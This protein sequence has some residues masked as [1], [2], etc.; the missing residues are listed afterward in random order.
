MKG[1]KNQTKT[2]KQQQQQNP[3]KTQPLNLSIITDEF[4]KGEEIVCR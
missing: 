4:R 1:G 2:N 3:P